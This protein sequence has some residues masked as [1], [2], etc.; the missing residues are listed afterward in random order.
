MYS[1]CLICYTDGTAQTQA[2]V[3]LRVAHLKVQFE[4]TR[5]VHRADKCVQLQLMRDL[6]AHVQIQRITPGPRSAD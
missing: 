5:P 4:M 3:H 2:H 1:T 6:C